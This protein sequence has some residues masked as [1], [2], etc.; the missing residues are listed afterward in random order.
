MIKFIS[1]AFQYQMQHDLGSLLFSLNF[2]LAPRDHNPDRAKFKAHVVQY[3]I[4]LHNFSLIIFLIKRAF[5]LSRN[6]LLYQCALF[7]TFMVINQNCNGFK[8][9]NSGSPRCDRWSSTSPISAQ[10]ES[11]SVQI[12]GICNNLRMSDDCWLPNE[13][14]VYV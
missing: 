11:E 13:R 2:F 8:V 9:F 1:K 3:R 10:P 14:I 4:E 7:T 5:A 6:G 12:V